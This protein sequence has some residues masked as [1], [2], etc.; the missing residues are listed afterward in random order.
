MDNLDYR[1]PLPV[2]PVLMQQLPHEEAIA[3]LIALT[4]KVDDVLD[5]WDCNDA[6]LGDFASALIEHASLADLYD[7][8]VQL[9]KTLSPGS[10]LQ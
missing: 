2:A 8:R 3:F 6:D 1:Y 9:G 4:E 7:V 5:E 10:L